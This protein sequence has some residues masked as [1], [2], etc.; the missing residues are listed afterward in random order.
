LSVAVPLGLPHVESV[1]GHRIFGAASTNR[2]HKPPV[3]VE[4]SQKCQQL[5]HRAGCGYFW[6]AATLLGSGVK[7]LA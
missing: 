5:L 7:L 1:R 6:M 4:N 3:E 2:W